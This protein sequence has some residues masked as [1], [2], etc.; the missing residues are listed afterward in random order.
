MKI[1]PLAIV[2][3]AIALAI[4]MVIVSA[5]RSLSTLELMLWQVVSL[6]LGIYGSYRFGQSSAR[7]AAR[8][9]VKPHARAAVRRIV[10]LRDSLYR[11]SR[12]VQ[13]YQ[14]QDEDPRFSVIQAVIQEQIPAGR[15]AVED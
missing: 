10:S 9:V 14:L 11:L 13:T 3:G 1:V 7:D 6:A 2:S 15:A 8:D 4:A 5:I 12:R